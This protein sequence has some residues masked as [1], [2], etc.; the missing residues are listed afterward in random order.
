LNAEV[1]VTMDSTSIELP[2]S[3]IAAVTV[4]DGTVRIEFEPAYLIK[5][6]TGSLERTRWRQNGALVFEDAELDRQDPLPALP[7]ECSG[8]DV[9]ENVYTYRDMIPVPLA[10]RGQAHCSLKIADATVRVSAKAVRLE[11]R[12]TAKYIE[13]LRPE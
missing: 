6:M 8:G 10:S 5:S 4:E 2:G 12:E 9:G 11:M 3:T 1:S 13:H 7:A